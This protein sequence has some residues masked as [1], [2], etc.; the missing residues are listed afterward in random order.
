MKCALLF[1]KSY[2]FFNTLAKKKKKKKKKNKKY[3]SLVNKAN[4]L[5]YSNL[6]FHQLNVDVGMD[7]PLDTNLFALKMTPLTA[8]EKKRKEK[9]GLLSN[10]QITRE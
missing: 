10:V 8:K 1:Y 9:T 7:D 3:Y 5:S 6:L 4:L 2:G